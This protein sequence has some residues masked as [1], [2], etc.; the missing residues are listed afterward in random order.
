[1]APR[2]RRDRDR[3]EKPSTSVRKAEANRQNALKSTGPRT[4]KGKVYSRRNA[5]KHG[6]FARNLFSD[7]MV[8]AENPKEFQALLAQLREALEPVGRTEELEIEYIAVCWWKRARLWRHEN[9]EM[10]VALADVALRVSACSPRE[11]LSPEH[12]TLLLMLE[13]AQEKVKATGEMP[14]EL[15]AKIL[16][17]DPG[18]WTSAEE[19]A[20]KIARITDLQFLNKLVKEEKITPALAKGLLEEHPTYKEARARIVP[21]LQTNIAIFWLETQAKQKLESTQN[22]FYERQ[23][24]PNGDALDKILRYAGMIDNDR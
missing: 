9:A 20:R 21:L 5:L 2:Q 3:S 12:K 13:N 11:M 19:T 24:I 4:L 17:T 10:R 18:F 6:L 1:M 7:F 8:E 15:K 23:A 14:Q 16:A 22:V